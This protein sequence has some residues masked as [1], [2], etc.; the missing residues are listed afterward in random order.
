MFEDGVGAPSFF[1]SAKGEVNFVPFCIISKDVA[2]ET[3]VRDPIVMCDAFKNLN[4]LPRHYNAG[5]DALF[6]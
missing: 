6:V 3:A 2:H 5:G 1:C 4:P